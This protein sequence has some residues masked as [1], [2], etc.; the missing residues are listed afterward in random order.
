M[1]DAPVLPRDRHVRLPAPGAEIVVALRPLV[2][3]GCSVFAV[4]SF[5]NA[6]APTLFV[7]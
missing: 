7:A 3:N 2:M 4:A 5:V 6:E 1:A